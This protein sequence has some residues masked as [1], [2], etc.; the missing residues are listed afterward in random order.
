[1]KKRDASQGRSRKPGLS[2]TIGSVAVLLA[3]TSTALGLGMDAGASWGTFRP[4][5]TA[6]VFAGSS[7]FHGEE[8]PETA[9]GGVLS[10][11]R[12]ML[13]RQWLAHAGR[14]RTFAEEMDF[15]TSVFTSFNVGSYVSLRRSPAVAASTGVTPAATY[16]GLDN[17]TDPT[18][19]QSGE[20]KPTHPM[21]D[22]D[23][24]ALLMGA[25]LVGL[26]AL[27]RGPK[28]E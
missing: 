17:Q 19:T 7:Y 24:T 2:V 13:E 12:L 16:P 23:S 3:M 27:A 15:R 1:M 18:Y 5:A 6:G 4:L 11:H 20:R 22:S 26:L 10:G 8:T 14:I 21:P 25:A 9:S 28:A